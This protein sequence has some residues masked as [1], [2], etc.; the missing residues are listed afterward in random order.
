MFNYTV[1]H[2]QNKSCFHVCLPLNQFFKKVNIDLLITIRYDHY[3]K[4]TSVL[5]LNEAT[6]RQ[7]QLF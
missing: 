6:N 5:H 7:L 3:S 4:E 2:P 1:F